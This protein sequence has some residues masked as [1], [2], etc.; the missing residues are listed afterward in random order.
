[1]VLIGSENP[2]C[3]SEVSPCKCHL[4]HLVAPHLGEVDGEVEC[5]DDAVVAVGDGVLD[6]VG[7]RVHE[8]AALVPRA[9]LH[10]EMGNDNLNDL[11]V[12]ECGGQ[13]G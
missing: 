1:M 5:A 4:S 9:G 8:H 11:R 2:C 10:P 6:V 13:P 7:R 12:A 3:I